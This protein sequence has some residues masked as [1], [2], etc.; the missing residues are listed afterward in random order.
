MSAGPG[1]CQD[2]GREP[3]PAC[4]EP[5]AWILESRCALIG[6][7]DDTVGNPHRAQMS[8]FELF[9]LI[10]LLKLDKQF[11]VEQFEA[12]VSQSTLPSLL[13]AHLCPE[14]A[15][16]TYAAPQT[17]QP[18]YAAA[19]QASH[20]TVRCCAVLCRAVPCRAMPCHAVP[21]RA[22]AVAYCIMIFMN[23]DAMR[24]DATRRDAMRCGTARSKAR[25]IAIRYRERNQVTLSSYLLVV[26][27][28]LVSFSF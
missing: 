11:P 6:R 27:R 7:G 2:F 18:T 14:A 12:T 10:L 24:C 9:E 25:E 3:P 5:E 17:V 23:Y 15:P 13:L 4:L 1:Q 20:R 22:C 21:C 28:F 8:Q 26:F 16:V 19:P